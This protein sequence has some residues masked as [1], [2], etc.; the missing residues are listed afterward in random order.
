V[1][2]QYRVVN[3]IYWHRIISGDKIRCWRWSNRKRL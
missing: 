3:N 1:G 2:Y